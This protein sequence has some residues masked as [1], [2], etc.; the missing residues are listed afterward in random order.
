M[1]SEV[2]YVEIGLTCSGVCKALDRGMVKRRADK[3]SQYILTA[4]ERLTT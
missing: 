1:I 4:I 3:L 2:D